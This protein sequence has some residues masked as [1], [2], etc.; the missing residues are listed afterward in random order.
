V[1]LRFVDDRCFVGAGALS[2][3]SIVSL[4]P[5]TAIVLATF[6]GF[7]I[8]EAA[9]GQFIDMVVENVAPS[10]GQ[11][12]VMWVRSFATNAAK[13]TGYGVAGLV[14]TSVL[15]LATV[16][17]HLHFIFRVAEPRAWGQRVF[18]YWTVL[19]LGPVLVG[20]LLG[21]SGDIDAVVARLA[22]H[23]NAAEQAAHA[24]AAWLGHF[25]P[26][27]LQVLG[28]AA[29]YH[30]IPNRRLRWRHCFAGGAV[31]GLL[32]EA[33]KLGFSIF[34]SQMS[35]YGAIYGALAGV[36]IALLWMYI[37]WSVALLGAE[38][39]AVLT[40]REVVA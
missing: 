14:V 5:L 31:A 16:E 15:L 6:S 13:T 33:M 19:T 10:L 21:V 9:R 26:V 7:P 34:V 28:F 12:A 1:L 3:T 18:A 35:S 24:G 11:D 36:P 8:F 20:V 2:Y 22:A 30:L 32:L 29:L 17:E 4:V 23:P 38:T 27:L 40:E 25:V 37:F 39:A